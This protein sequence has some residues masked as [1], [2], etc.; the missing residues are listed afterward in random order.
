MS[1]ATGPEAKEYQRQ[2][3]RHRDWWTMPTHERMRVLTYEAGYDDG[4][5]QAI[6]D[7]AGA[8][9]NEPYCAVGTERIGGA[10]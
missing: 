8:W 4:Y 10:A 2:R 5:E 9:A 6:A 3:D 7:I 1:T